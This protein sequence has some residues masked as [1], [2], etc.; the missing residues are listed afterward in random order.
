MKGLQQNVNLVAAPCDYFEQEDVRS[1]SRNDSLRSRIPSVITDDR[2]VPFRRVLL[3][4]FRHRTGAIAL[5]V[6]DL[7]SE[8]GDR[9]PTFDGSED[10][11]FDAPEYGVT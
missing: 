4:Q 10:L 5:A 2:R 9:V 11:E 6:V 3:D 7:H 8:R 1:V